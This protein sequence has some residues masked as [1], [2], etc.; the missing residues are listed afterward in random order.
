MNGERGVIQVHRWKA[1]A[2]NKDGRMF[3]FA[4]TML[5][6]NSKLVPFTG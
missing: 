2:L 6:G 5:E 3:T 4:V 1:H